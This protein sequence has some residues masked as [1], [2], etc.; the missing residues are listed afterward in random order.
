MFKFQHGLAQDS[1]EVKDIESGVEECEQSGYSN[2]LPDIHVEAEAAECVKTIST[3]KDFTREEENEREGRGGFFQKMRKM[4]QE[5]HSEVSA[6]TAPR[7]TGRIIDGRLAYHRELSWQCRTWL[8]VAALA[9]AIMLAAI[10]L[11]L[12]F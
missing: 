5:L 3:K 1:K 10:V 4:A 12:T 8:V 9:I 11:S 2:L 6:K 7:Q